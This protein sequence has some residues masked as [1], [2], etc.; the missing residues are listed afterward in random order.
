[1]KYYFIRR[2][3]LMAFEYHTCAKISMIHQTPN[4][5]V[6]ILTDE[7]TGDQYIAT[8]VPIKSEKLVAPNTVDQLLKGMEDIT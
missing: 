1:M 5:W 7:I 8:F 4:G 2:I 6:T 3:L